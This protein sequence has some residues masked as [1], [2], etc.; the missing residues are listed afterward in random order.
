[1]RA[2]IT[3]GM[4]VIGSMVARRFVQEGHRP[5]LWHDIWTEA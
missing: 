3:G 4:G 1:M 5:V 2:L